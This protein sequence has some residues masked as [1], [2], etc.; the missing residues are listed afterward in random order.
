MKLIKT[1]SK[2]YRKDLNQ[3]ECYK[4]L[5]GIKYYLYTNKK[6]FG[7]RKLFFKKRKRNFSGLE[8]LWVTNRLNYLIDQDPFM[9]QKTIDYHF[10]KLIK[11]ADNQHLKSDNLRDSNFISKNPFSV[12]HIN[13]EEKENEELYLNN[14]KILKFENCD[15]WELI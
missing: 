8:M 6:G 7:R 1:I 2:H 10:N 4:S 12:F 13:K 11:D 3:I 5:L 14:A 9:D 15:S